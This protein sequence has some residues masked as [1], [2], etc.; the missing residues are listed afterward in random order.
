M[1]LLLSMYISS[2]FNGDIYSQLCQLVVFATIVEL[3]L[4]SENRCA[5]VRLMPLVFFYVH[6]YC[7]CYWQTRQGSANCATKSLNHKVDIFYVKPGCVEIFATIH[8]A[9]L[10][11]LIGN[12]DV[13]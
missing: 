7:Y 5:N 3:P 11:Y 6:C 9:L 1:L 8:K 4:L 10:D 12:V 13:S 2:F